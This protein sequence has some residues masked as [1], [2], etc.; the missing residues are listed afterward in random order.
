M[1]PILIAL[2]VGYLIDE[3]TSSEKEKPT[4]KVEGYFVFVRSDETGK[5]NLI[6]DTY[7]EARN[8]FYKI[9]KSGKVKYKD[10]LDNSEFEKKHYDSMIEK[11]WT[12]EGEGVNSPDEEIIVTEL[13][14]GKGEEEFETKEF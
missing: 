7:D 5:S 4:Q 10:I 14:W 6:F 9:K 13:S 11:G 12:K 3:L 8:M 1:L 2:G